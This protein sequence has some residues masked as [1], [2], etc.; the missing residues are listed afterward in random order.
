MLSL[1][2][3]AVMLAVAGEGFT[4]RNP[5]TASPAFRDCK[6]C[7]EMVMIPAGSFTMGSPASE[8]VPSENPQHLVT[9]ARPFAAGKS[10]VTFNEWDACVRDGGCSHKPDDR[11]WGRG[12]RPVIYVSWDDAQQYVQWLSRKTARNYRLL[13]EAEWEY[14]A[15]AGSTTAYSHGDSIITPQQANYY[16]WQT[17]L[18]ASY[19]PNAFGL[20]DVHGNVWEWTADCWNGNYSGAPTN[21]DAWTSGD[22]SRRVFRGGSW[23]DYPVFLRSADRSNGPASVRLAELGFRVAR[24]Q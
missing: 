4:Q 22:C 12:L 17:T 19:A 2:S 11:G 8:R 20:Y 15:R 9:I 1:A 6:V 16:T 14:V 13:S 23:T 3:L 21:G 7:P 18:V 24:M 10:E 5:V